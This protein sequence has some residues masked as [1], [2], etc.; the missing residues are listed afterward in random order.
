MKTL[1]RKSDKAE[2]LRR[3]RGLRPDS[4]PRWG[5]MSATPFTFLRGSAHAV[6]CVRRKRKAFFHRLDERIGVR[7]GH[8]PTHLARNDELGNACNIGRDDRPP[9][10][11]CFHENHR[12]TF[13]QAGLNENAR[14][15][16]FIANCAAADPA[17]D[18]NARHESK[19]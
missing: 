5:R 12:K 15:E 6:K 16:N 3:L 19:L 2:L 13:L 17:G 9:K 4:R 8:Q 18:A 10:S 7:G 14:A 1:A 11:H